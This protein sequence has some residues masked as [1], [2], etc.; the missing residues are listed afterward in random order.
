MA[1]TT[2]SRAAAAAAL[3]AYALTYGQPSYDTRDRG[4]QRDLIVDLLTDTLHLAD[5]CCFDVDE[6][7]RAAVDNCAWE[8]SR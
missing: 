3:D 5:R 7:V 6:L 4:E 1:D 2:T 8:A